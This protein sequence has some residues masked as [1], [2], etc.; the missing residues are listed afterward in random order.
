MISTS[1]FYMNVSDFIGK[2]LHLCGVDN[3][4]REREREREGEREIERCWFEKTPTF[5]PYFV[6]TP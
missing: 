3:N 2:W 1:G 4:K 5:S 6:N